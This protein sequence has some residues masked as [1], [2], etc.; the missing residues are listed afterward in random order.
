MEYTQSGDFLHFNGPVM[1]LNI[2]RMFR[3]Y[4]FLEHINPDFA[5]VAAP[6]ENLG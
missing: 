2:P 1:V 3:D 4:I 5:I 6:N